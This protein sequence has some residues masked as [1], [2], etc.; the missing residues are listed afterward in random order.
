MFFK[1]SWW[2]T[3]LGQA[4]ISFILIWW[5]CDIGFGQEI[6]NIKVGYD[7]DIKG[8]SYALLENRD[9]KWEVVKVSRDAMIRENENQEI[10]LVKKPRLEVDY[11]D[12]LQVQAKSR[13]R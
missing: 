1:T 10:L 9:E 5:S 6:L 7:P 8:M 11:K 4:L 12:R 13:R 2:S 3:L